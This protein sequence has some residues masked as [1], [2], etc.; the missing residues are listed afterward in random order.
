MTEMGQFTRKGIYSN[1]WVRN[2]EGKWFELT[3]A[4]FTADATARK[5]SRLDYAGGSEGN[6]FFLKN[7]GF[8]SDRT[9]IDSFFRRTKL[10]IEPG[11]EFDKLP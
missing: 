1:Q 4:K 9:S 3:E 7:C 2:T 6:H 10:G 11:I 5:N 8:F